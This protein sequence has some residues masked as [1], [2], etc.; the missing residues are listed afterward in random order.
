MPKKYIFIIILFISFPF[1]IFISGILIALSP[2]FFTDM[3]LEISCS[4]KEQKCE[5][6]SIKFYQP[7][8]YI[9]VAKKL[10]KSNPEKSE[11]IKD[12]L[13]KHFSEPKQEFLISDIKGFSCRKL[14]YKTWGDYSANISLNNKKNVVLG[15]YKNQHDCEQACEI[16]KSQI[17][18]NGE[19]EKY[20]LMFKE[21]HS[22]DMKKYSYKYRKGKIKEIKTVNTNLKQSSID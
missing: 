4:S 22:E 13:F 15:L 2:I 11:E 10:E 19:V 1:L 21:D 14:F 18:K 12:K 17:E 16:A 20:S 5:S 7:F 6:Y 3:P 8:L 9:F